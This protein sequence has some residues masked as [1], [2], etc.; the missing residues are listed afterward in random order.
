M[1]PTTPSGTRTLRICRPFGLVHSDKA[2]PTGSGRLAT[3]R[4]PATMAAM[5]SGLSRRRSRIA[6]A[7]PEESR[8]AWF[9]CIILVALPE[10]AS[11]IATSMEFFCALVSCARCTAA[12]R[13]RKS[14]PR[15]E[16][17]V[18]R[19][20][21]IRR[22]PALWREIGPDLALECPRNSL[23]MASIGDS[24]AGTSFAGHLGCAQ[25]GAHAS[26]SQFALALAQ[27]FH[28]RCELAHCAQQARTLSI[29]D[30]EAVHIGK[31]KQPV[32]LDRLGQQGAELIV[33]SEGSY[34]FAHRNAVVL[35]YHR[36]HAE[37]QQL[38]QGILQVAI[39]DRRREVIAR[40]QELRYHFLAE[41]KLLV[42]MHQQALPH[43]GAGLHERHT[44]WPF[45]KPQM[46][47]AGGDRARTDDQILM[48]GYVELIDQ[49][50][51]ARSVDAASGRNQTGADF[52][53]EAHVRPSNLPI[54]EDLGE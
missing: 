19:L 25:L 17:G 46:G 45:R 39:T 20:V 27:G 50:A 37:I 9:A 2:S 13:A 21:A 12:S 51:H 15:V 8:S 22:L 18:L 41:K 38:V 40:E 53:D 54:Q 29:G 24:D 31:Q 10:I 1:T 36:H 6:P 34:Q 23:G 28:V 26:R 35:V 3:S 43:R 48:E 49:R 47:H 16:V 42:S 11:A 4:T 7:S 44:G 32:G 52:D 30:E 14:L 5:R 33:V